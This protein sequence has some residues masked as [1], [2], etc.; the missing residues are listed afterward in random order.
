MSAVSG[1]SLTESQSTLKWKTQP[2]PQTV[3][4]E[5]TISFTCLA[6]YSR[7]IHS[8]EWQRD[9]VTLPTDSRYS[10]QDEHR[11]L[12][13][14]PTK[15]EDRGDYRCLAIRKGKVIGISQNAALNVRGMSII[16]P[17]LLRYLGRT[18][19][20]PELSFLCQFVSFLA[21]CFHDFLRGGAQ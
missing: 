2:K 14:S 19:V 9:N 16:Q 4:V 20:F 10:F 6:E 3:D 5:S 12:Q 17:I 18:S 15:F 11:T 1:S 8:Y 7:K 21:A 13:I